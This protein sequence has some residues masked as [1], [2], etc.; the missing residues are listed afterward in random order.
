MYAQF[1]F[2]NSIGIIVPILGPFFM[3][4]S[5]V[6]VFECMWKFV[7]HLNR[8]S[9]K[10]SLEDRMQI[11]NIYLFAIFLHI[12]YAGKHKVKT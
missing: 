1:S 9:F 12:E 4:T 11:N 3:N 5:R 10:N 8:A 7:Q 2:K 6:Y